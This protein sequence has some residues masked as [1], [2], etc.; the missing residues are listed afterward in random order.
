MESLHK[1][2]S[3]PS[4]IK[5]I[6]VTYLGINKPAGGQILDKN[7]IWSFSRFHLIRVLIV[8]KESVPIVPE[9]YFFKP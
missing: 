8:G 4:G 5:G 9:N 2:L 3:G 7:C 1:W 6:Y